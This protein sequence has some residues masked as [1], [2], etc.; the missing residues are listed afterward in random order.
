MTRVA[1][2]G[3]C[4]IELS[5]ARRA[6]ARA[7]L[8]GDVY[9]VAVS[10]ARWGTDVAFVSRARRRPL[11]RGDARRL[12]RRGHRHEP[13]RPAPRL[14]ARALHDPHR[15][16][17][18][19]LVHLLALGLA[20]A[21]AAG[22][23]RPRRA[24]ARRARRD[25]LAAAVRHLA[26]AAVRRR[27][28]APARPARRADRRRHAR[29]VR[30]QLPPGRLARRRHRCRAHGPRRPAAR[31]P[32][33]RSTSPTPT[34]S[35]PCST[36]SSASTY[37]S[38]APASSTPTP[39]RHVE[40]DRWDEVFATNV[41][42]T[43]L[44]CKHALPLL[45]ES[46]GAIVNVASVAGLVGVPNRAAYCASKGAVLALTRA[47]AIDHVARGRARQRAV[48]RHDADAV[49][50]AARR[51]SRA[52]SSRTSRPASPS[53]AWGRPRRW[54]TGRSISRAPSRRSSRARSSWS[55]AG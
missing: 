50:R 55:T 21:R 23:R 54:R 6:H 29:R 7:R 53:A 38:T 13:H 34:R 17:R 42:G 22:R 28:R 47:M 33:S 11:Q 26:V 3:E 32:P 14:R 49:D 40:I 8:R 16:R 19:A 5:R 51:A 18:R 30:L 4:M 41:R 36:G 9:N 37:S 12:A 43:F 46:R 48:P 27:P 10:L 24:R 44:M 31:P 35:P 2:M 52:R 45:R 1:V 15:R 39:S 25:R 20:G